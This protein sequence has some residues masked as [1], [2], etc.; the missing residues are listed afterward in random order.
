L[1]T[2]HI[3]TAMSRPLPS[4]I[5]LKG[6]KHLLDTV[7]AMVS[8]SRLAAGQK[9]ISYCAAN[10]GSGRA[11]VI[12]S[13][14]MTGAVQAAFAN[15]MLAH[16][17]ETDDSHAPSLTHPGC[18]VIPAALA[19]AETRKMSGGALLRA[20]VVGYD[21]G[22]RIS[23]ALGGEKFFIQHHSSHAVGGF[24]GA[25][26]AAGALL[27]LNEDRGRSLLG[28]AVQMASVNACWRRDPDHIEKAFDFGG[29]P[30]MNG[31]LAAEMVASGFTGV[32]DA[33]EGNTGLF[34]AFPQNAE[35]TLAIQGLNEMFEIS[36]TA[37][38]KWCV[39]SPI[40]ALDAPDILMKERALTPEDVAEIVVAFPQMSSCVVDDRDMPDVN[41]QHQLAVLLLDGSV[42]CRSDCG[43]EH[44]SRPSGGGSC[45]NLSEPPL[46]VRRRF[47][48]M[49]QYLPGSRPAA[50]RRWD[51]VRARQVFHRVDLGASAAARGG[52]RLRVRKTGG[53][54]DCG[55]RS[56]SAGETEYLHRR[57][58]LGEFHGG[59][60][61]ISRSRHG[62][63]G[64]R[65]LPQSCAAE[66][67]TRISC[68]IARRA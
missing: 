51:S 49:P 46:K 61:A 38:K 22:P 32:R 60:Y 20:V 18:A 55:A 3:A 10:G 15:G 17:D 12:G 36:R 33:L 25:A 37:I 65:R 44:R 26:A 56:R 59:L 68:K 29:T 34:S 30:A 66:S 67:P 19:V 47:H 41:L 39:G 40:Q 8:A 28:Y 42:P 16:A 11:S 53:F 58:D 62:R 52:R 54:R 4:E 14:L 1:L 21:V 9:A 43:H 64:H 2:Q 57:G 45:R 24:F 35:P 13:P 48:R 7:A 5:A 23:M 27:G 50:R 31:T 6:R 63:T